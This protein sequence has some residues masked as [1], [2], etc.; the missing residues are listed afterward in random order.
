MCRLFGLSSAPRRSRATFWLL[1]APD[2]LTT[3]SHRDPDGTGLGYFDADGAP[4]VRKAPD[5][6]YEDRDFAREARRISSATFL[7]HIR[8]ASTGSLTDANTHPFQQDGR[9]FAH[10]GVIEDL[11]AL[12]AHLGA[13]MGLVRGDTDSER[14][15]ALVTREIRDAGGDIGRGIERAAR[16]AAAHLPVYSLNF[17]LITADE[18]WALRYPATHELYVLEREA[19][20]PHGGRHLD[21][22]GTAGRMRVHSGDLADAPACVVA[23]E[24]MDEHPDWR[25]MEPGTL[26]HVASDGRTEQ[27]PAVPDPPARPLDLSDLSDRAAHSQTAGG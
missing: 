15:F 18:L 24:P 27:R 22:S 16:W 26:L 7:A 12:E 5:A 1:D 6:A 23:S 19:G 4:Q 20:G 17:V 11:P 25:L 21:H 14:F 10:N 8:L 13:D 3:Q 9:L 2:S